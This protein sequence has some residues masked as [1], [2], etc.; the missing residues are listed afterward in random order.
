[1]NRQPISVGN[2]PPA[3]VKVVRSLYHSIFLGS[4]QGN[5]DYLLYGFA[6]LIGVEIALTS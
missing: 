2:M 4:F 1:M 6:T 3:T 5:V